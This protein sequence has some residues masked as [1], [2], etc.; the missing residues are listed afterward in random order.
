MRKD[1]VL[2]LL[3]RHG[4]CLLARMLLMLKVVSW[5]CVV[6]LCMLVGRLVGLVG[7]GCPVEN[8]GVCVGCAL[9]L[10]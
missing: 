8:T 9:V 1:P 7:L 4:S 3:V 2:S 10:D 5:T 6:C